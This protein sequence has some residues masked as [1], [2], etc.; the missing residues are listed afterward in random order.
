MAGNL[1]AIGLADAALELEMALRESAVE[2]Y[3]PFIDQFKAALHQ[4]LTTARRVDKILGDQLE[5][6][7]PE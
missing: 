7:V 5:G 2:D 6:A 1:S 3:A 4:F